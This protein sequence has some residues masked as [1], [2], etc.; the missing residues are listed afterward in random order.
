MEDT[1][2]LVRQ[3]LLSDDMILAPDA[4]A[5][6]P[7]LAA[8]VRGVSDMDCWVLLL[9]SAPMGGHVAVP[10]SMQPDRKHGGGE[11][12]VVSTTMRVACRHERTSSM[13]LFASSKL[14]LL[15][16]SCR[17]AGCCSWLVQWP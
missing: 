14:P 15:S 5:A 9:I 4:E 1:V 12:D 16:L 2:Q 10:A 13:S 8:Q 3:R 7:Q 11:D 17:A 6:L